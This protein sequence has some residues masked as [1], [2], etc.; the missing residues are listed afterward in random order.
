M[1]WLVLERPWLRRR[2]ISHSSPT[3][4]K[5]TTLEALDCLQR[6]ALD[7]EKGTAN[8]VIAGRAIAYRFRDGALT[9]NYRLVDLSLGSNRAA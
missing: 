9:G 1:G 6:I 4:V 5:S 2:R 8:I 3:A 7:S